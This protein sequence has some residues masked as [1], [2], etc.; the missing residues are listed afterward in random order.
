MGLA[1]VKIGVI[2]MQVLNVVISGLA[3]RARSS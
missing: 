2:T 1:S 3:L